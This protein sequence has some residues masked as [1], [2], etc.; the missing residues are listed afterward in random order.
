MKTKVFILAAMM[1]LAAACDKDTPTQ[2]AL[3][4][5]K[6]N[7]VSQ[8]MLLGTWSEPFHV[9]SVVRSLLFKEDGTLIYG[10]QP[11]TTF[12]IVFPWAPTSTVMQY[13]I[14]SN[15]ICIS[16]ECTKYPLD[17]P[18]YTESFSYTTGCSIHDDELSIESFSYDGVTTIKPLMLY[19]Q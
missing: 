11:D 7:V 10:E 4:T 17:G 2:P 19:K 1:V 16:G 3:E 12:N 13:E 5:Q 8:E 6:S 9:T 18:S 15:K 14:K